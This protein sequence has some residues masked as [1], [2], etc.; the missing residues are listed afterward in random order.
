MRGVFPACHQKRPPCQTGHRA[1]TLVQ[2][3]RH[4]FLEPAITLPPSFSSL[5]QKMVTQGGV[6]LCQ[7]KRT[8]SLR[9]IGIVGDTTP[10]E[11]PPATASL[12]FLPLLFFSLRENKSTALGHEAIRH[13]D[14]RRQ[15]R[16]SPGLLPA[17]L[18]FTLEL[19]VIL[20]DEGCN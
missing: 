11:P 12:P 20:L 7:L 6:R 14:R 2:S 19:F 18:F 5:L 10:S 13:Q 17:S 1:I 3:P 16:S 8:G 4:R 9:Q 15:R